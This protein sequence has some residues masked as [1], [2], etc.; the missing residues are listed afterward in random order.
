MKKILILLLLIPSFLIAQDINI[1]SQGASLYDCST[2]GQ[3]YDS[4]GSAGSYAAGESFVLIVCSTPPP[5]AGTP[6]AFE[7]VSSNFGHQNDFMAIY[8]GAG[9]TNAADLIYSFS[10][11]SSQ[12]VGSIYRTSIANASGCITI[13]FVSDA[14]SPGGDIEFNTLCLAPCKSVVANTPNSS[15]AV[16]ASEPTYIHSCDDTPIT[17]TGS[18]TYDASATGYPQSDATSNFYWDFGAGGFDTGQVVNV[19]F[20]SGIYPIK[21]IV[22]DASGCQ[23]FNEVDLSVRQTL[24]PDVRFL[25]TDTTVCVG[26]TVDVSGYLIS[27]SGQNLFVG[28]TAFSDTLNV[29]TSVSI[30]DTAYLPDDADGIT[31]N[32]ITTPAVYEFPIFGYQPGATLQNVNDLTYVCLDIE[33]SYIGDLDILVECPNGQTVALVDFSPPGNALG[34]DFGE[35]ITGTTPG[36]IGIP[37]TYC[38][39]PSA[40]P[41]DSIAQGNTG[42]NILTNGAVDT[43]INYFP[44]E[45]SWAGLI[46]CPLN[47]NW[48]IQV[49]DDFGGDDGNVFGASIEFDAAYSLNPDT[50]VVSY[51]NPT[52]NANSQ[53]LTALNNDSISVLPNNPFQALTFNFGDNLGCSWTE[54]YDGITVSNIE[55]NNTFKDTTICSTAQLNV[56]AIPDNLPTTNCVYTIDMFDNFG[57]SWNGNNII[58]YADG[59]FIDSFTIDSGSQNI[60]TIEATDYE[61]QTLTFEYDGAGNFQYEVEFTIIDPLGN[62][63]VDEGPTPTVGVVYSTISSCYP[64]YTFQWTSNTNSIIEGANSYK[65]TIAPTADSEYYIVVQNQYGCEAFDTST[66]TFD[67][68]NTPV[69]D[70]S[71]VPVQLC[72][73][74]EKSFDLSGYVSGPSI[75][76]ISANNLALTNNSLLVNTDFFVED[77]IIYNI[78]YSSNNGC[79]ASQELVFYKNCI[80]PSI[81]ISDTIFAGDSKVFSLVTE[82]TYANMTYEWSTTDNSDGAITDPNVQEAEFNGV[83]ENPYVVTATATALISQNDGSTLNCPESSESKDYY[84]VDVLNLSYP[85]AFSPN[86][87]NINNVFRPVMSEFGEIEAFR[88]YNRWGDKVYDIAE[89]ENKEGWDGKYKDKDQAPGL[90]TYFVIIRNFNEVVKTEGTVTLL[91]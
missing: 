48:S 14:A 24:V 36:Q 78:V 64:T 75:S 13:Q 91:R 72:C 33:H 84:V 30:S 76:G 66:L 23:S 79:E 18:G 80:N 62:I 77:S 44:V 59:I 86:A 27:S 1:G 39:S 15:I 9:T 82:N 38:W 85:D 41:S 8:D 26:E 5:P 47:G 73:E 19:S 67:A 69:I 53:I 89:N 81:E 55:V 29:Q 6:V 7:Y 45:G 52:W 11:T 87:D 43:S 16:Q 50:F 71:D 17:F 70:F 88:I 83:F 4:G 37:Y 35:P 46:G 31:G 90:Y 49:F 34:N 65:P 25:P 63:V 20:T 40:T 21:L 10:Q 54:T 60:E 74:D 57:D 22:E 32:G 68:T 56:L 51:E 3:L 61:G 2:N 28:D 58:V 12:A 42:L